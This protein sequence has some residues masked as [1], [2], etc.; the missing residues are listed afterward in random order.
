MM[1]VNNKY[2]F[3]ASA[4]IIYDHLYNNTDANIANDIRQFQNWSQMDSA[5]KSKNL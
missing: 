4:N 1:F 2:S 5:Y 3:Q